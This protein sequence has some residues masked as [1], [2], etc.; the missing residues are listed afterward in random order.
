[1]GTRI[2]QDKL[3]FFI[4]LLPYHQPV[5]SNM[6]FPTAFIFA[7]QLMRKVLFGKTSLFLQNIK[8]RRKLSNVKTTT[9]ASFKSMKKRFITIMLFPTICNKTPVTSLLR[10][11]NQNPQL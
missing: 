11:Q 5:W 1:M 2:N 9:D 4:K 6:T 8:N 7:L 10:F 3:Q